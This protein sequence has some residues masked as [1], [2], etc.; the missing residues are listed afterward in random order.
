MLEKV[1]GAWSFLLVNMN[2]LSLLN[3][4]PPCSSGSL[5]ATGDHFAEIIVRHA[6][7]SVA[8]E[9]ASVLVL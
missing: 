2:K 4:L 7:V 1:T 3:E 6:R 8:H 9:K 5:G